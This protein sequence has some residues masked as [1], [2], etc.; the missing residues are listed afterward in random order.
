MRRGLF[1]ASLH[2]LLFLFFSR[3][4]FLTVKLLWLMDSVACQKQRDDVST[5]KKLTPECVVPKTL[6][7]TNKDD[8]DD[9]DDAESLS[10]EDM[11][12]SVHQNLMHII[13]SNQTEEGILAADQLSDDCKTPPPFSPLQKDINTSPG[14]PIKVKPGDKRKNNIQLGLSKK[15]EF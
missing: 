1:G 15:L 12:K 14:A 4:A 2:S 11:F 8:A 7:I 9:A 5:K 10:Y 13:L 6:R 3:G